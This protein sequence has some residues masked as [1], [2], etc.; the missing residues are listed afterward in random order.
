MSDIRNKTTQEI[1]R[2]WDG[3]LETRRDAGKE[4]A[5]TIFKIIVVSPKEEHNGE[6]WVSWKTIYSGY[7]RNPAQDKATER[8]LKTLEELGILDMCIDEHRRLYRILCD[9]PAPI[10]M[11]EHELRIYNELIKE[12]RLSNETGIKLNVA[13][14]M[15]RARGEPFPEHEI[16]RRYAGTKPNAR[17]GD[18]GLATLLLLGGPGW[19]PSETQTTCKECGEPLQ[20]KRKD[21]RF[22]SNKCKQ[23]NYN[24]RLREKK[25]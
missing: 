18:P 4:H 9:D 11:D 14:A 24:N 12:R 6:L 3:F 8:I 7:K 5:K 10:I 23:A 15:L 1:K 17:T 25:V 20:E 19:V 13:M 2:L 16:N 21:A 22:C